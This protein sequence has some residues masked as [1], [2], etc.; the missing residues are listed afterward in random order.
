MGR[1]A[2][3]SLAWRPVTPPA[4]GD[5]WTGLSAEPLPVSAAAAWV[6]RPECGATV[7]F[8]GTAR[9][10]SEGRR[11]VTRLEY[12]AYETPALRRL[13][14]VDGAIRARW[15]E[16]G[17]TVLLHR[18]GVVPTGESAVVV[19]VSAGHRD[20]AFEAAR[21]AI[22]AVKATVPIWKRETWAGGDAWGVD[23][24]HVVDLEDFE[25]P[26]GTRQ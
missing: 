15:P 18:L 25:W 7:V 26:G 13:A 12:E 14:D 23:A 20:T 21:F 17:R 4:S 8:S 5:S 1:N 2:R 3:F 22:D 9:N 6:G 16:V 19:A 24:Q 10:H 11:D